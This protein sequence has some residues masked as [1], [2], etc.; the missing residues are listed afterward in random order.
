MRLIYCKIAILIIFFF[1]PLTFRGG[2]YGSVQG[3]ELKYNIETHATFSGGANT[4]FW[5]VSNLYGL[6]SP[7][8][9]NGWVRGNLTRTLDADKR[10][11]WGAGIDLAGGWN[12]ITPFRIQQLYGEL[13]YRSLYIMAGAKELPSYYNNRRLSSGDLIFSGNAMPI[14]QFRIGTYDFA[15][16]WGTKGWFSVRAYLAYGKF[17]YSKWEKDWVIPGTDRTAGVLFCSRGLWFRFGNQKKFPLTFD[18]GIEMGTQF[19]GTIYKDRKA[20]KMPSGFI[21][22]IKALIPLQGDEDTPVGEQTNVQGNMT[23]EYNIA[24]A[25]APTPDWKIKLYFEHYFEDHSQMFLEYGPWKD[26]LWGL[27]LS[28]PKNRFV[29]KLV[30]E[31]VATKDQTGAV[32]HDW[33]PEIP[34]QVSGRD[35][36]YTHYLYNAWQNWGMTIGTPLAISPIYN[37]DHL[38][39]MYNTRFYANHVGIEGKPLDELGWRMLLT[40]TRNW[41]SYW[42]PLPKIMDNCS[43]LLELCYTPKWGKGFSAKGALAWDRGKLLGNNFGGMVSISYEGLIKTKKQI[44]KP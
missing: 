8:L 37:K 29:S 22:W 17:T 6:G 34:Q 31:F 36:Y 21:D 5:L 30:Y 12:L 10:F 4:P 11:S 26:G 3:G 39:T 40:F 24:L 32:N 38:M 7:D 43:G 15:P 19:G 28:F 2:E 41:G 23:G 14:P 20:F 16:F 18:M 42:R 1:I 33:T 44:Q 35:G 13:K 9:N 27:E 25:Y